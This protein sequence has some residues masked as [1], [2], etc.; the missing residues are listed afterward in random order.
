MLMEHNETQ[1]KTLINNGTN[2]FCSTNNSFNQH[3]PTVHFCYIVINYQ[4]RWKDYITLSKK[5]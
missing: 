2:D 4:F 5:N 1:S 3:F